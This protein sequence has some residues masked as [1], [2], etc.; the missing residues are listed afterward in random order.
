MKKTAFLLVFLGVAVV[1]GCG[2]KEDSGYSFS[3]PAWAEGKWVFTGGTVTV[4]IFTF[5]DNNI[6]KYTTINGVVKHDYDFRTEY[7]DSALIDDKSGHISDSGG[8]SYYNVYLT[9]ASEKISYSF[10]VL[11]SSPSRM[12]VISY[13]N[14][15]S[16]GVEFLEKQ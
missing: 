15:A 10:Q 9:T 3:Y 8:L 5:S 14:D 11:D 13:K 2:E 4:D 1:C 7:S 16:S 12:K 6:F